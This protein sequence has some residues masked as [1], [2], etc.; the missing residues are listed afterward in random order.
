MS[1]LTE[2]ER[3]L[4]AGRGSFSSPRDDIMIRH[5]QIQTAQVRATLAVL[6]QLQ[7]IAHLLRQQIHNTPS[8]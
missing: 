3:L 7:E 1:H 4:E 8:V 6:E 2:A 5:L